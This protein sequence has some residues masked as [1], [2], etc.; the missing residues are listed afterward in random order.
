[1]SQVLPVAGRVACW[2]AVL[3]ISCGREA[4]T[5]VNPS[6]A[7]ANQLAAEWGLETFALVKFYSPN[8]EILVRPDSLAVV[9]ARQ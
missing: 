7:L 4:Q 5:K 2:L 3:A 6:A 9:I 8:P 1:M